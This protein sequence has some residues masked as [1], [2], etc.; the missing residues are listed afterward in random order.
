METIRATEIWQKAGVY[1]VRTEAMV[2]GFQISPEMEFDDDRPDSIYILA[3]DGIY[4]VGTCR[5][6]L[7]EDQK[8]AKIERVCV[9][10]EYR[11][12]GVG[13]MVI[14]AAEEWLRELGTEKIVITSRDEAVGFYQK[15]GYR[16]DFDKIV[17]TGIFR[18]IYT[19]KTLERKDK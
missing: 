13:R 14:E 16:A 19:E 8:T 7:L 4:P 6:H 5:L 9:I 18:I 1:F 12:K 3:T 2:K 10:E 11:K 15:L 17:E